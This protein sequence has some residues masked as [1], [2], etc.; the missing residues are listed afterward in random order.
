MP[1]LQAEEIGIARSEFDEY[2]KPPWFDRYDNGFAI[3]IA[4][5]AAAIGLIAAVW[6]LAHEAARKAAPRLKSIAAEV[7]NKYDP[8]AKVVTKYRLTIAALI[9]LIFFAWM[10]RYEYLSTN[11]IRVDRFTGTVERFDSDGWHNVQ[12]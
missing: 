2:S 8:I 11:L 7:R 3:G 6:W 12:E 10:F 4:L 5:I 9:V 1:H